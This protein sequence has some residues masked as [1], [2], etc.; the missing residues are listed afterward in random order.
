M[1][2]NCLQ[3]CSAGIIAVDLAKRLMIGR[4]NSLAIVVSTENLTQALYLGNDKSFL[5]QN[6][7]FRCGM[8]FAVV[9]SKLSLLLIIQVVPLFCYRTSGRTPSHRSLS[10]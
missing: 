7:L 8:H 9:L 10:Y 6:I 5:L 1:H 3:G 2:S 4:P